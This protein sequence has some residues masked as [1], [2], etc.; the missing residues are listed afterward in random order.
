VP[1]WIGILIAAVCLVGIIVVLSPLFL[2]PSLVTTDQTVDLGKEFA[3]IAVALSIVQIYIGYVQAVIAKRQDEQLNRRAELWVYGTPFR[4]GTC[5]DHIQIYVS[6][7][8]VRLSTLL[9]SV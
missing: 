4:L 8:V 1:R 6:M 3:V 2:K 5:T 7:K 9:L